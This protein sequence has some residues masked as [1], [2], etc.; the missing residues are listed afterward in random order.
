MDVDDVR[1]YGDMT[2]FATLLNEAQF[3]NYGYGA[4]FVDDRAPCTVALCMISVS[5]LD[6]TSRNEIFYSERLAGH[7]KLFPSFWRLHNEIVTFSFLSK[8]QQALI[9]RQRFR[10]RSAKPGIVETF[11]QSWNQARG[12][13]KHS[14]WVSLD[15]TTD[16]NLSTKA[17]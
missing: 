9:C 14:G 16:T 8:L 3:S 15:R 13:S 17:S 5:F 6:S 2:V 12:L 1:T 4:G 11:V 10:T 7:Q